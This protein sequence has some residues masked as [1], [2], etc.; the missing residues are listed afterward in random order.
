MT[1][2]DTVSSLSI[3]YLAA[4]EATEVTLFPQERNHLL[5][6]SGSR[7]KVAI[8]QQGFFRPVRAKR[9]CCGP[10]ERDKANPAVSWTSRYQSSAM[11]QE[12]RTDERDRG[13]HSPPTPFMANVR[14]NSC[15]EVCFQ[16]RKAWRKFAVSLKPRAYAMSS[17]V[18]CVSRKYF[19]ATSARN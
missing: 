10:K 15:G 13:H 3:H 1:L 5:P 18:I 19:I 7:R 16:R 9:A 14:L 6:L 2:P 11:N 4:M 8:G 17:T 12:V